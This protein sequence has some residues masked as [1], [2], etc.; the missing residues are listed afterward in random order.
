MSWETPLAPESESKKPIVKETA[1]IH[2]HPV[3]NGLRIIDFNIG[4]KALKENFQIGGSEDEKGY[5]GFSLRIRL[6]EDIRFFSDGEELIPQTLGIAAG[7]WVDMRA[8]FS[9]AGAKPLGIALFCHPDFPA[10]EQLW[11][12]RSKRSM[13]NPAFPGT[14]LLTIEKGKNLTTEISTGIV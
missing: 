2:I 5:S 14:K 11:I 13:Q 8:S 10:A 9:K 1:L 4:L 3:A 7:P 6:P 12:L